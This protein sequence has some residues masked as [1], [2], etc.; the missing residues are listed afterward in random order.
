MGEGGGVRVA[1]GH[2]LSISPRNTLLEPKQKS[3][4]TPE[5]VSSNQGRIRLEMS[6][7]RESRLPGFGG[8]VFR[9]ACKA[10]SR[11]G[12][13]SIYG[14]RGSCGAYPT[15]ARTV[16]V[17]CLDVLLLETVNA[18]HARAIERVS[19]EA[20]KTLGLLVSR[21]PRALQRGRLRG[22]RRPHGRAPAAGLSCSVTLAAMYMI[23][24]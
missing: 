5:V 13:I 2:F 1:R 12:R 15:E 24:A 14:G 18:Y 23:H 16:S 6:R 19:S 11:I 17:Q 8:G 3:W 21:L 4:V 22:R 10:R 20:L 9:D 7:C